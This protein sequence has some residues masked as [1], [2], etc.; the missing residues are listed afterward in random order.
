MDVLNERIVDEAFKFEADPLKWEDEIT[1]SIV[2]DYNEFKRLPESGSKLVYR[3]WMRTVD[4]FTS[5]FNALEDKGITLITT[6]ENYESAHHITGWLDVFKG[7]TPRTAIIPSSL[8]VEEGSHAV[9]A[10]AEKLSASSFIV[11]DFVKSRKDEWETA[12]FAEN[13]EALP[14]IVER[15]VELQE[16]YLVGGIAIREFVNLDKSIPE[17]RVW[18]THGS[19]TLQTVHP[20]FSGQTLPVIPDSFLYQVKEAVET[21]GSPFVT[22]DIAFLENGELIVIEVGDGQVSGFPESITEDEVVHL[23]KN[24]L[25]LPTE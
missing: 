8:Y 11:K 23:F 10:A 15:F 22:T 5:M 20:D 7:L 24:A 3:G 2:S 21:L 19:P 13:L 1:V 17:V 16:D 18:W 9:I 6:P 25:G 14:Q 4:E 12:C